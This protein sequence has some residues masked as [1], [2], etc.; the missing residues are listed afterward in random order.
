M[1]KTNLVWLVLFIVIIV[2]IVVG[3]VVFLWQNS[4][5]KTV[6]SKFKNEITGFQNTIS[7]LQENN[8]Y[9]DF[10]PKELQKKDNTVTLIP[11]EG[12]Y[13]ISSI[14][15]NKKDKIVYSEI[16]NSIRNE[17]RQFSKYNIFVKDLITNKITKIYSYPEKMS[18]WNF[19]IK[20]ANAACGNIQYFPIAWS[21]NDEKI[22]LEWASLD[23]FG[24][25]GGP[26][27]ETYTINPDGGEITGLAAHDALFFDN[28]GQVVYT[29]N[30]KKSPP[31]C[32][33]ISSNE[34]AIIL[35]NI[36][37]NSRKVL[38]EENNS[39]YTLLNINEYQK[40][41]VLTYTIKRVY[42]KVE[43]VE[44]CGYINESIP[45]IVLK[46]EIK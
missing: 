31:A 2:A 1:K 41:S 10:L 43:G 16:N 40:L 28:Y 15:S 35:K 24:C 5:L 44:R 9:L 45:E 8:K 30:S 22:I 11:D 18:F 27:Y 19:F 17:S 3:G 25:G 6:E 21:K 42:E 33:M 46:L 39:Y 29:D 7:Q 12:F 37:N 23:E 32:G 26:Q 36:E 34:G 20:S 4:K 38:L 14:L 13:I